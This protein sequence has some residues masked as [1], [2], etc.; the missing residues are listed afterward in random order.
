LT[1][2]LVSPTFRDDA[3]IPSIHT[4]E[5][6]DVSPALSWSGLPNGSRSLAFVCEDPDAPTSTWYHWGVF[7]I[8]ATTSELPEGFPVN[9]RV[10]V[11]RQA[12][13]SFRRIGY[14]RPCP[15]PGHG[16]HRHRFRLFALSVDRLNFSAHPTCPAVAA[17]ASQNALAETVLTG[18][19]ER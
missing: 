13:N 12:T 10:G 19:Y 15:P 2:R 18:L 8:P 17:A 16:P 5:G 1:P 9:R 6:G 14:G 7:D 3:R 4:C 11:I